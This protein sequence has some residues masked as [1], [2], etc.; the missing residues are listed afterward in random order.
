M[1]SN[2]ENGVDAP[3]IIAAAGDAVPPAGATA[4]ETTGSEVRA[5]ETLSALF[6]DS[7][8]EAVVAVLQALRGND[9]AIAPTLRAVLADPDRIRAIEDSGLLDGTPNPG[10]DEA[11][12]LTVDALGVPYAAVNVITADGQTQAA[13]AWSAGDVEGSR[14][15]PLLDSL[16]VLAVASGSPLVI[17]DIADHPVLSGHSTATKGEVTAYI[18]IPLADNDGHVIGTFCASDSAPHHWSATEV[19]LISDLSV[20]VRELIFGA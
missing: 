1:S 20:V 19:Q 8:D 3:E 2:I 7:P 13:L 12:R 15:R 6:A 18:G 5:G 4:S 11:V 16:C 17:D 10:L 14:T 9:T